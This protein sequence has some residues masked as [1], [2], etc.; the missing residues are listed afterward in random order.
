[1]KTQ[2][3]IEFE[4]ELPEGILKVL[5]IY[6]NDVCSQDKDGYGWGGGKHTLVTTNI[7]KDEQ[8]D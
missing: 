3:V 1:M 6:L 8:G 2:I 7:N 4:D 5:V